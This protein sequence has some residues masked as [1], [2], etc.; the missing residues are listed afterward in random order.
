[1]DTPERIRHAYKVIAEAHGIGETTMEDYER[2]RVRE[3]L[4]RADA[5]LTPEHVDAR[6]KQILRDAGEPASD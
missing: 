1:M 6:L 2:F 5:S 3:Q 4:R